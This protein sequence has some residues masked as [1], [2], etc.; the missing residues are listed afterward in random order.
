[1]I[2][3][4]TLF[5]ALAGC[6]PFRNQSLSTEAMSED[7]TFNLARI[8]IGMN[9]EQVLRI[10]RHPYSQKTFKHNGD[11]YDVWFYVTRLTAMD[12][13]RLLPQ[14]L[15]PLTFKN[16]RLVGWGYPY[17]NYLLRQER[18]GTKVQASPPTQPQLQP[19]TQREDDN[20]EK[21]LETPSSKNQPQPAPKQPAP[22]Q[23]A[24]KQQQ[25]T[26]KKPPS[27]PQKQ[28]P[29][30]YPDTIIPI[31]AP[32]GPPAKPNPKQ[33]QPKAPQVTPRGPQP[34]L[35]PTQPKSPKQP[36]QPIQKDPLQTQPEQPPS[37][38]QPP[39]EHPNDPISLGEKPLAMC[40]R[41]TS[42]PTTQPTQESETDPASED[43]D[44]KPGPY[45]DEEGEKMIEE[46][47]EQNFDFW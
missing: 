37:P 8:S 11:V 15:T 47:N 7:N 14:N 3:I 2:W 34:P 12:Q 9:E 20:I 39:I 23:P 5:F 21:I 24:P 38:V 6:S 35:P 45:L 18:E 1:M 10:M 30:D 26:Q 33:K 41:P 13:S 16:G 32:P 44:E 25:P 27:Q 17:Y 43:G 42:S 4:W 22:K 40:T 46:E 28:E 31:P 36:Q 19:P 29:D